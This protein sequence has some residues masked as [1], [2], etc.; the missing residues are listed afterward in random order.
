MGFG[1]IALIVASGLMQNVGQIG[2]SRLTQQLFGTATWGLT[3]ALVGLGV[4][5]IT[6]GFMLGAAIT[7]RLAPRSQ[8]AHLILTGR[9]VPTAALLVALALGA[10]GVSH[11]V[12]TF[13]LTIFVGFGNGLTIANTNAGAIS[14]RPDLAGT[15]AGL[16]GALAVALG[17]LLSWLTAH[18]IER[19]T[20]PAT[21]GVLML[22]CVLL[23]LAAALAAI[24]M[25]HQ[26]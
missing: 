25:D 20:S 1:V 5:S 16:S 26:T 22:A 4:G 19:N 24:R 10:F 15:A 18:F 21:L 9:L 3:P 14:V 8:P 6:G 17:A 12:A 11:P 13:G 2:D 23:S 7:A